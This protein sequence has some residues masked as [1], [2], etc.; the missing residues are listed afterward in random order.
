[1]GPPLVGFNVFV[2]DL[3]VQERIRFL[4]LQEATLPRNTRSKSVRHVAVSFHLG[5]PLGL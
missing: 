4:G 3:N 2:E 1:M 5:Y